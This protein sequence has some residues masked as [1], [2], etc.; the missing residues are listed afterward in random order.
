MRRRAFVI[1]ALRHRAVVAA[2][3]GTTASVVSGCSEPQQLRASDPTFSGNPMVSGERQML[4]V[5]LSRT[6]NTKALAEIIHDRVGGALVQ[7]EVET[8]YPSDYSATVQQV[9]R[10]NETGYLPPLKTKIERIEEYDVVFLGFPTWG[11]QL[12]PPIKSFLREYNL[13]GKTVVPFNTNAGYGVGNSF[14]T[15]KELCRGCT[16]AE[17]FTTRGGI[18]RDGRYLVIT[19]TRAQEVQNEVES[20]LRRIEKTMNR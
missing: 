13:S 2:L 8:Q 20:W 17:G 18:E 12:P 19:G 6:G 14:D 4:I 7:L 10:E 15:L 9:A 11:M 1:T 16:V 5:Y 3:I